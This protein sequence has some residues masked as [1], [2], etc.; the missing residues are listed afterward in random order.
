M[1]RFILLVSILAIFVPS[2]CLASDDFD[3]TVYR[4]EGPS[5]VDLYTNKKQLGCEVMSLPLLTIAPNRGAA[6]SSNKAMPYDLA[7]FPPDWFDYDG[8]VGSLRNRLTQGGGLYGIQDWLDYG[9][10]AESLYPVRRVKS[11]FLGLD[12]QDRPS[13]EIDDFNIGVGVSSLLRI[14]RHAA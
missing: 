12:R 2:L 8:S 3:S 9:L 14:R 11:G 10:L 13:H 6:M 5:G 7:P 1:L 4:C